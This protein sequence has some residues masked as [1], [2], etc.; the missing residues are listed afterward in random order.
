M[1]FSYPNFIIDELKMKINRVSEQGNSN[2]LSLFL[3]N[4][5][6]KQALNRKSSDGKTF[7]ISYLQLQCRLAVTSIEKGSSLADID[8]V[9][10]SSTD[11]VSICSMN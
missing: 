9:D 6:R 3:G 4:N 11:W 1:N 5:A 2:N 10:A 8:L 7:L